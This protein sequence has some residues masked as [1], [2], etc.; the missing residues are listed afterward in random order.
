MN[1][2]ICA[3]CE[4]MTGPCTL[5]NGNACVMAPYFPS[6]EP[7][8]FDRVNK[9]FGV[10]NVYKILSRLEEPWQ[11]QYAVNALCYEAEARIHDPI[12]GYL[13]P[14]M[15][16]NNILN[17]LK[18]EIDSAKNELSITMAKKNQ[19]MGLPDVDARRNVDEIVGM[20]ENDQGDVHRADG[21]S[22]SSGPSSG[23]PNQNQP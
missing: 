14:Q 19:L 5:G 11:R 16:Y 12:H 22:T 8:K 17:N 1:F 15:V 4:F 21:A 18:R 7:E 20:R 10:V 6:T 13:G 23:P 9:V 3:A 2:A